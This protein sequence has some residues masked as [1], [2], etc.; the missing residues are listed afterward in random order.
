MGMLQ[1]MKLSAAR[2]CTNFPTETGKEMGSDCPSLKEQLI[3]FS[4]G[5]KP[6][7]SFRRESFVVAGLACRQILFQHGKISP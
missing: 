1:G 5:R 7:R 4:V 3:I 6:G 2:H